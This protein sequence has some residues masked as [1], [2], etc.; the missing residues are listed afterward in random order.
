MEKGIKPPVSGAAWQRE[1][2]K[3]RVL[4]LTREVSHNKLNAL[5]SSPSGRHAA[6]GHT[7]PPTNPERE[8]QP[9]AQTRVATDGGLCFWKRALLRRKE[10]RKM[11]VG[12]LLSRCSAFRCRVTTA[13][14]N[15]GIR[16]VQHARFGPF[17]YEVISPATCP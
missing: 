12:C 3:G 17:R 9:D 10:S 4:S 6:L 2:R 15:S 13:E 14:L 16:R 7:L 1:T 11:P 8:G 5:A